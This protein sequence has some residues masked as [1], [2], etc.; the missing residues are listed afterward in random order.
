MT[1]T[2]T[3]QNNVSSNTD[4]TLILSGSS[5][6]SQ[7]S[8]MQ[9]GAMFT[10][11]PVAIGLDNSSNTFKICRNSTGNISS[12]EHIVIDSSGNVGI[13]ATAPARTLHISDT[14]SGATTG[15]RL[16]GANNGSQVIEFA[17]TDDTNVGY[18]QYDHGNNR[19][20]VR[21]GDAN[22]LNID[23]DGLKFG[24]DT[25]SANALDD[26]EH[27]TWTPVFKDSSNATITGSLYSATY[28]KVG[29]IVCA[30]VYFNVGDLQNGNLTSMTL[31]FS[32]R[33]D[34]GNVRQP[35][36][37]VTYGCPIGNKQ[38]TTHIADN[39]SV[40]NFWQLRDNATALFYMTVDNGSELIFSWTYQTD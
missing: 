39:S 24:T 34:D 17:D 5:N 21:A 25:A 37:V 28:T 14:T 22:R 12:G 8:Y 30:Q 1:N 2:L 33:G 7:D 10:S 3:I 4:P 13:G 27:G 9:M 23:S 36:S 40:A 19:I 6:A 16:T 15:I 11:N 31:P 20:S 18:I 38:N 26:Y 32:G 35:G 29:Q